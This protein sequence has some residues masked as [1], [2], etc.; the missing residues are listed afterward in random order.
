MLG[1]FDLVAVPIGAYEPKAMMRY[2][3]LTP[4]Q[5]LQAALDVRAKRAMGVHYGTFDLTDEP[6]DEP[7]RRFNEAAK[8]LSVAAER[9]WTLKIGETRA[10]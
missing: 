5:A 4:E 7:P 9:V 3:H 6:V 1:P 10:W 8:E 2:V